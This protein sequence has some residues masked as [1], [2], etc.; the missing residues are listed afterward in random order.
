MPR[1]IFS[2]NV[3]ADCGKPYLAR[4]TI[5]GE[6][7]RDV[8]ELGRCPARE[9]RKWRFAPVSMSKFR[10]AYFCIS[11]RSIRV[12]QLLYSG[13]SGGDGARL[14]SLFSVCGK[15]AISRPIGCS[16]RMAGYGRARMR[17]ET[18]R[19]CFVALEENLKIKAQ[20]IL[21][22]ALQ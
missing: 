11:G 7:R 12:C 17:Y 19:H 2:G 22:S 21:A 20:L 4:Q 13:N 10:R 15:I 9:G 6:R 5:G 16:S 18:W 8:G 14:N 3:V 1:A